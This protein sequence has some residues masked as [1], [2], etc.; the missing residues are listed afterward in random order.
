MP[1]WNPVY[2]RTSTK[3]W[4]TQQDFEN[5]DSTTSTPTIPTNVDTATVPGD[6]L[7]SQYATQSITESFDTTTNRDSGAT[8]AEWN[9][10]EGRL[11]LTNSGSQ[12]V[13]KNF[14]GK[15]AATFGSGK[16]IDTLAASGNKVYFTLRNYPSPTIFAVYNETNDAVTDLTS[17]VSAAVGTNTPYLYAHPTNGDIY[18]FGYGIYSKVVSY[19]SS[20]QA[21][22][23]LSL[24]GGYAYAVTADTV[25]NTLYIGTNLSTNFFVKYDLGTSSVTNL[26]GKFST[27]Y[28]VSSVE[29]VHYSDGRVY[30]IGKGYYRGML[31]YYDIAGDSVVPLN[32]YIANI[33]GS[34]AKIVSMA[35]TGSLTFTAAY[36]YGSARG[37]FYKHDSSSDVFT[38]LS[39][40]LPVT[41]ATILD[42]VVAN[43]N[44]LYILGLSS[45][46]YTR[47]WWR[48]NID[49]GT[50]TDLSSTVGSGFG[51][52]Y[53]SSNPPPRMA[54]HAGRNEIYIITQIS[55]SL[56]KYDITNSTA[57]DVSAA[58]SFSSP[59]YGRFY[60]V[61]VNDSN[62]KVYLGGES[63]YGMVVE[64]DPA[65]NSG[66][67]RGPAFTPTM[68]AT[69][70]KTI[71][72][73]SD[74][75]ILYLAGGYGK[76]VAYDAA[77]NTITDKSSK[78]SSFWR[79]Y[80][81]YPSYQWGMQP[82]WF[83]SLTYSSSTQEI[84]LAGPSGEGGTLFAKYKP[85]TDTATN[86]QSSIVA[87]IDSGLES[88]VFSYAP[89]ASRLLIAPQ[90][91]S[92]G[93]GTAVSY[94]TASM[95]IAT[96]FSSSIAKNSST[97]RELL[98][99]TADSTHNVYVGIYGTSGVIKYNSQDN[100]VVD[101]TAQMTAAGF[102][103]D[104]MYVSFNGTTS[105]VFVWADSTAIKFAKYD[106]VTNT[107]T[108]LASAMNLW[109]TFISAPSIR[110]GYVDQSDGDV[111]VAGYYGSFGKYTASQGTGA[112]LVPKIQDYY[113]PSA[114]ITAMDRDPQNGKL[115]FGL[116]NRKMVF[117]VSTEQFTDITSRFPGNNCSYVVS[118]RYV[119]SSG[120][121]F[122]GADAGQCGGDNNGLYKY[123][124]ASDTAVVLMQWA[125]GG[126]PESMAFDPV[127]NDLY[128]GTSNWQ[129]GFKKYNMTSGAFTDLMPKIS[130]FWPT[131]LE[132]AFMAFD[133]FNRKVLF[134]TKYAPYGNPTPFFAEYDIATDTA[135]NLTSKITAWGN[136]Y[137]GAM[138]Y[139]SDRHEIYIG[140]DNASGF[141][142]YN[143]ATQIYT[144]LTAAFTSVFGGTTITG[145]A[146][147]P[148]EQ[149]VYIG[150]T[151]NN[152]GTFNPGTGLAASLS[153]LFSTYPSSGNYSAGLVFNGSN[154]TLYFGG[155][156]LFR[157][158]VMPV[159][160]GLG[161][162]KT[163][164]GTNE[165]IG[166]G[167]V[168][169]SAT[170]GTGALR[171][172]LTNNGGT[173][174]TEA[175]P[176]EQLF[177]ST[178]GSDLRFKVELTGDA[179]V[180]DLTVAYGGYYSTAALSGMKFDG[181]APTDWGELSWIVDL[182]GQTVQLFSRSADTEGGLVSA[183]WS[184]AYS[185]S[186]DP[187]VSPR[188]RWLELKAEMASNGIT[189][190]ALHTIS[191][192][193]VTNGPPELRGDAT[194]TNVVASQ[195]SSGIVT[196]LFDVRDPDT[197]NGTL[198]AGRLD[199]SM[200]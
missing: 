42:M 21:V 17:L 198:N 113:Y 70:V 49:A 9:T 43:N 62:G 1:L 196:A 164:D 144:D 190:P 123:D 143:P 172:F 137:I 111:F 109:P 199:I 68:G 22:T 55:P 155:Q 79:Y 35:A 7:V 74:A 181:G 148:A 171:Y 48:Y 84:F 32:E 119:E 166:W 179:T 72:Y 151:G 135:T 99:I 61:A 124:P 183:E 187:I 117:D 39:S 112:N 108:N 8:N 94:D 186:G 16:E 58:V 88:A 147:L 167:M 138:T 163:I 52:G 176:D 95:S 178:Q 69:T 173:N 65:T 120:E 91:T 83:G 71:A 10:S 3:A 169:R 157:A 188:S 106:P 191:L 30:V 47:Y 189:T 24:P 76:F 131:G 45:S 127:G 129:G 162:S 132:P 57:S 63:G 29:S 6:V 159:P 23:N 102:S 192:S 170:P 59:N 33:T 31:F 2:A 126:H 145:L 56:W 174:W 38:D 121:I 82:A 85:S 200:D 40:L 152:I 153:S 118:I 168:S 64:Y 100:S 11:K 158:L 97:Y 149:L 96:N 46:G 161:Q 184:S 89:S 13:P 194:H 66:I 27:N 141:V 86:L 36:D 140:S 128:M 116:N 193:Y 125:S 139:D 15:V 77:T 156:T 44:N 160:V 154:N 53:L 60:A 90:S 134:A 78:I 114:S 136:K 34:N 93:Y 122:F 133:S 98:S 20:T 101:L 5:N 130:S 50:I 182:N 165:G 142:R 80:G 103:N 25:N 185:S 197:N 51:S 26:T 87:T 75:H 18:L 54:Y 12:P 37:K 104:A 92:K 146:Y 4:T 180:E 195:G 175:F 28:G 115:Y 73:D 41:G 150:A 81:Y 110:K 107:T 67:D 19:N 14:A 177:F 105:E